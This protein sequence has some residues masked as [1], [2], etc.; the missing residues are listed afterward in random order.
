MTEGRIKKLIINVPPR[1]GKSTLVSVLWPCW[2]WINAPHRRWM[3]ATY[4]MGL[5]LRDSVRRRDNILAS[6]WYQS[7]WGDRFQMEHGQQMK[8]FYTNSKSGYM[9][10]TSTGG[11][12][13]GYGGERL[14]LDDP[15]DPK[16]AESEIVR[17][18]TTEWLNRTWPTRRNSPD[19]AEVLIMQRLHE[20]DAT[21]IFL[22]HG[23]WV[24]LKIPMEFTGEPNR[25]ITGYQDERTAVGQSIDPVRFPPDGL[26]DLKRRLGPFGTAGQ[27]QQEPAPLEGGIVKAAWLRPFEWIDERTISTMGGFYKFD[28]WQTLRFCTVDPAVTEKEAGAKKMNDPDY[29]VIASWVAFATPKG[30][31]LALLDL[32]RERME[33]PDIVPAIER[34][35]HQWKFA[36]I[37]V[38]SVAFQLMLFQQAKRLGLP[39]REIS[40]KNDPDVLYRLDRDKMS[41]LIAATPLMADGRFHVPT[42]AAWLAEYQRELLLFPNSAH[43]DMVDATSSAVAIAQTFKGFPVYTPGPKP[44]QSSE[45]YRRDLDLPVDPMG[46]FNVRPPPGY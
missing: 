22:K 39:V 46:H 15:H 3:F 27:L 31:I 10:S 24:H 21:G 42:H 7:R 33:G 4:R 41:R 12:V 6:E 37:G 35:H 36:V 34:L 38:E 32:M 43:D 20:L 25:T 2:E 19:A 23:G 40:T 45:H 5:S 18:S 29:T 8:H 9:F 14:L 1:T 16:G 11:Q 17:E 30:P 28:I 26:D 13:T 44:I